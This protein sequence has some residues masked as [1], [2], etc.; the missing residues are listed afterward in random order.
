[1]IVLK[2]FYPA[3]LESC[4]VDKGWTIWQLCVEMTAAGCGVTYAGARAWVKGRSVPR[5]DALGALSTVFSVPVDNFF[6]EFNE[7][8]GICGHQ[9]SSLHGVSRPAEASACAGS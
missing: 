7:D 1:M 5:A 2:V 9:E 4:L 8:R 6:T 3:F